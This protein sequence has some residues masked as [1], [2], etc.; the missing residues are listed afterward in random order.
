MKSPSFPEGVLLA[1]SAGVL[2]SVTYLVLPGVI[3]LESTSRALITGLGLGYVIY[4]L[5]RSRERTGRVV[6]LAAWL[7]L[8]GTSWFLI[9]DP[10]A[11]LG[12]HLGLIWLIRSLYHQP[13]PLAALIDLALS[14]FAL[15]AGV[16]AFAHADSIF[17]AV[18]TFFLVQAAFVGIP[19]RFGQRPRGGATPGHPSDRFQL[20]YRGAEAALR[21]LSSHP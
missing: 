20:A 9:M 17:M 16:W 8:A 19:S 18:W 1:L 11:Y 4:L 5:H 2:S 12:L 15:T 13:G 14:L 10:L 7:L 6:T 21:K 3:G